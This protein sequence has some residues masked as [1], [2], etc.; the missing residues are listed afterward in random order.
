MPTA[1]E[2]FETNL[3]AQ[4]ERLFKTAD[5]A[6]AAARHTPASL[7]QKMTAGLAIGQANKDGEGI[8]GTCKALGVKHNYTAIRQF[9]N[10]Q[11]PRHV[12]AQ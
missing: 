6:M 1:R 12:T 4:Y 5:Y 3:A 11:E 2:R 9:L 10:C 7:A 8:E